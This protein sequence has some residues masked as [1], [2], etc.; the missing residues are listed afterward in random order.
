V[1]AAGFPAFECRFEG[2]AGCQG[3]RFEVEGMREVLE[4]GDVGVDSD[5]LHT[6]LD[7]VQFRQTGAQA[8]FVTDDARVFGHGVADGALQSTDVL[9]SVGG[10][11]FVDLA[12]G[13]G[14]GC[15][16]AGLGG[17]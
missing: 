14:D 4:P 10:E 8:L 9:G 15:R 13:L 2:G 5:V 6:L 1:A 11:E 16:G 3:G 17:E 12:T 7:D